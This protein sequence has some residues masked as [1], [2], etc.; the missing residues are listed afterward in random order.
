MCLDKKICLSTPRFPA[1]APRPSE[2]SLRPRGHAAAPP[3]SGCRYGHRRANRKPSFLPSGN[4]PVSGSSTPEAGARSQTVTFDD[5][6]QAGTGE[7]HKESS[8]G[9]DD[10]AMKAQHERMSRFYETMRALSDAII[11]G[12]FKAA[13]KTPRV[14]STATSRGTK[15]TSPT[16]TWPGRRSS[17]ASTWRW[18][19]GRK[20]SSPR[21]RRADSPRRASPTGGP[22]RSALP[23]TE[24]SGIREADPPGHRRRITPPS[25]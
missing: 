23:A 10:T 16:R 3:S 19:K 22:S 4:G 12:D 21:S 17:T 11:N 6:A 24:S 14:C 1:S 2:Q 15:K 9:H 18:R 20:L 8:S 7:G 13:G 25:G 5:D